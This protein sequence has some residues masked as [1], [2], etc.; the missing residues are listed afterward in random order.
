MNQT[1]DASA[2]FAPLW[3]RKWLILMVGLL[4]GA[5]TYLYYRHQPRTFSS[6]VQVY[7]GS[8][9]EEQG[10][11]TTNQAKSSLSDRTLTDQVALINSPA[12]GQVVREQL[13]AEHDHAAVAGT[14][15]AKNTSGSD[16]IGITAEAHTAKGAEKLARTYAQVYIRRQHETYQRDIRKGL[17]VARKQLH[18]IE[19]AQ[20]QAAAQS[21]AA[22]GATGAKGKG[23]TSGGKPTSSAAAALQESTIASRINQLESD[24]SIASVEEIATPKAKAELVSSSPKRNAVFGFVLGLVLASLAAYLLSRFDR[25]LQSVAAIESAFRAEILTVLPHARQPVVRVDGAVRPAHA[26]LEP[27]RRLHTTLEMGAAHDPDGVARTI[28]LVS[29]D[30]GDGKSTV[31][32]DLALVAADSGARVAVVEADFRRPVLARLLNVGGEEGLA[33]VLAGRRSV[34][35]AL[36]RVQGASQQLAA[37]GGGEQGGGEQGGVGTLVGAASVGSLSLLAGSTAVSNPPALLAHS[38]TAE[39]LRSLGEDHDRVLVDA[40]APLEVSDAIPLL[41]AVDGVVVVAR[42]G[43]TRELSARRLV[44]LL[45]RAAAPVLGVVVNDA[46]RS[47]LA[48]YGLSAEPRGGLLHRSRPSR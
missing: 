15:K 37:V 18:R 30:A 20:A 8:G 22:T 12:I 35:D 44:E 39:L 45:E 19:Q 7:L 34:L 1:T 23:K 33:D 41:G 46:P 17:A 25:R 42:I 10:L 5:L 21:S 29:P 40:P 36:Q 3:K 26:L 6:S 43:H 32:A 47:A 24:L 4:V 14:A 2:I 11:F 27:L 48:S 28:L 9:S 13:K 31:A 16:F 38:T